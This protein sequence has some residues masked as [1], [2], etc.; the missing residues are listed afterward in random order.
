MKQLFVKKSKQL[1]IIKSFKVPIL[2][3]Y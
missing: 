1:I 2:F 3:G